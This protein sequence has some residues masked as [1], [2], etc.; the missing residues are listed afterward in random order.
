[1]IKKNALRTLWYSL[2]SNQRF[3]IRKL[4]YF[5]V[6]FYDRLTGN[7]HKYVPPRGYIYTGSPANYEDYIDQGKH[8]LGLLKSEIDLKPNDCVLDVGSGIG[9]TAIALTTYLDTSARYE[10]FDVVELGVEWCDSKI[11]KDFP[12]FNFKYIPLFNDLYNNA[13]LKAKEF[14]FPYEK[15]YFDK[16]FSFSVFT[17]MQI[18]E[19]QKYFSEIQKVLKP[20]GIAFSTF[21]LYDDTT[22]NQTQINKEFTFT[23]KK[24]GY[25]LMSDKVKSANIA[26]HKDKLKTMLEF[27]NLTLVKIIDGFWKGNQENKIEYQDIVI[28]KKK[29]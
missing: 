4:Y 26:I 2:S 10:G 21:F 28:F 24:D 6:D 15:N 18:D 3:L 14:I 7:Y 19:I 17:H 5:P 25:S 20:N 16:I 8:Q 9:R 12:N 11:K 22:E 27:E 29:S 13:N 23:K 1:M